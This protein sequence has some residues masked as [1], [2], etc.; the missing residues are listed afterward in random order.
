MEE[1][2]FIHSFMSEDSY[3]WQTSDNTVKKDFFHSTNIEILIK[4]LKEKKKLCEIT[5]TEMK[6]L[7]IFFP[8]AKI[9]LFK[10]M[11]R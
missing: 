1:Q 11:Q 3:D 8:L 2:N 9:I 10:T 5:A 7:Q 4:R 6:L